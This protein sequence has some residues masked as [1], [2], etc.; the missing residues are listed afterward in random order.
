M[1]TVLYV[2]DDRSSAEPLTLFLRRR[3]HS[4]VCTT[5]GE[6]ALS[7]L[8][9]VSPDVI[10]LDLQMPLMDGVEFLNILRCY[11]KWA[12]LPVVI[13]T[14]DSPLLD[15]VTQLGGAK[16]ANVVNIFRKPLTYSDIA[17]SIDQCAPPKAAARGGG[18]M[19]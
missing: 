8:L 9:I 2:E 5:N 18:S 7:T 15:R 6:E 3:G 19:N 16:P 14:A 11:R 17:A 12:E 4:V 10:V 1:A 13:V